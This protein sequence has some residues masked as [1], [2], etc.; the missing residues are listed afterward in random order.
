MKI[1]LVGPSWPFK[2]GIAYHTTLL[3]RELRRRHTVQFHSFSRQ[4]PA[5][6]YP[7]ESDRDESNLALKEEEARPTI[8]SLNPFSL[9]RTV[10]AIVAF[11]P[12]LLVLPWWVM[13]WAPHFTWLA[14]ALKRRRPDCRVVFICHNV[15]AHDSGAVSRLLTQ[16]TLRNGDGFL[17]QSGRDREQLLSMLPTAHVQQIPHPVYRLYDRQT[18]DREAA[19]RALQLQG[20]VALCFGFVRPYKGVN[21]LLEALPAVLQEVDLQTVVVGEFWGGTDTYRE[22]LRRLGLL[23]RVRLVDRYIP[24]DEVKYWFAACDVV[25]M[26][27]LEATGSG[28]LKLAYGCGRTAIASDVGSLGEEIIDAETGLLVPPGDASA[29]AGALI[30]FYRD[31]LRDRLESGVVRRGRDDGWGEVVTALENLCQRPRAAAGKT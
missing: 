17:V 26:P 6:L 13:F 25:V 30:R 14:K 9:F 31:G 27:Y 8:D 15:S 16:W 22:T 24:H 1:A 12:D 23:D 21:V 20:N 7:G 5:W 3:Y 10:R 19:R 29:L 2:G 4:Y 18:V 28:V 11:E